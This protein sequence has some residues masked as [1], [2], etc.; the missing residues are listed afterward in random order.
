MGVKGFFRKEG[1]CFSFFF[2]RLSQVS[3]VFSLILT[4]RACQ[5]P[6]FQRQTSRRGCSPCSRGR[7]EEKR[8]NKGSGEG[9]Q[10]GG[11]MKRGWRR[12]L[13][14]RGWPGGEESSAR[15]DDPEREECWRT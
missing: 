10:V 14:S 4:P 9:E 13:W 5:D 8:E 2:R 6:N 11:R 15:S 3:G 7:T 1:V 12:L